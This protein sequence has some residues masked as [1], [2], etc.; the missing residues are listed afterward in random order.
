MVVRELHM[1]QQPPALHTTLI[2]AIL[3]TRPMT[4]VFHWV[5]SNSSCKPTPREKIIHEVTIPHLR[6]TMSIRKT[7]HY[8]ILL[9]FTRF[10]LFHLTNLYLLKTMV[11]SVINYTGSNDAYGVV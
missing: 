11:Q 2:P 8:L 6:Q 10:V 4:K 1:E 7:T 9:N 3:V 5:L